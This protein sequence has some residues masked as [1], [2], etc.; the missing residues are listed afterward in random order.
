MAVVVI[1]GV[2]G[3]AMSSE[4]AVTFDVIRTDSA[5]GGADGPSDS[6]FSIASAFAQTTS[7][8]GLTGFDMLQ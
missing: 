3:F 2:S 8:E 5:S 4:G 1:K 7:S 6:S